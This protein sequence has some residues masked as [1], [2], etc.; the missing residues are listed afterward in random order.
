MRRRSGGGLG[1]VNA[2]PA[3]AAYIVTFSE[4]GSDVVASG[5][6]SIDLTGLLLSSNESTG[7]FVDAVSG[8]EI[9]GAITGAQFDTSFYGDATGPSNFGPGNAFSTGIASGDLVGIFGDGL[10]SAAVVVPFGYVSGAP[11]LDTATYT[12]QSFA[13]LGLTP[14]TYVYSFGSG[15]SADTLTVQIGSAAVPEPAGLTLLGAGLLGLG[16][17]LARR[18][19]V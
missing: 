2:T 16:L 11:L 17:G 15:A 3:H 10:G 14:G 6:G 12:G 9:T 1:L 19:P 13:S 18:K 4:T 5:S 8:E 7:S